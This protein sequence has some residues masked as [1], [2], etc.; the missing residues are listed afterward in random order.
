[1]ATENAERGRRRGRPPGSRNQPRPVVTVD[2]SRC[3]KCGSTE[4]GPYTRNHE[5]PLAGLTRDGKPATHL[6]RRWTKCL[7]CGQARIDRSYE[8][9]HGEEGRAAA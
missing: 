6:V 9:R 5:T 2:A 4:R 8:N 7:S 1:M 3:P